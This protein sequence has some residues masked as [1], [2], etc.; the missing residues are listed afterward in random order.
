MHFVDTRKVVGL[1]NGAEDFTFPDPHNDLEL[2]H[3]APPKILLRKNQD[4]SYSKEGVLEKI[5]ADNES[6]K[7]LTLEKFQVSIYDSSNQAVERAEF[8]PG[9]LIDWEED[10]KRNVSFIIG[11]THILL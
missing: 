8:G 4:F 10:F 9:T 11:W 3:K 7:H 6:R 1:W 2:N 5:E